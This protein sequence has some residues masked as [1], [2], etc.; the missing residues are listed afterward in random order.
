VSEGSQRQLVLPATASA[1]ETAAIVAALARY[2]SDVEAPE[3]GAA[4]RESEW[5]R[6]ARAEAL[7][8]ELPAF[9]GA[10]EA[11]NQNS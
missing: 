2:L 3:S 9:W 7:R 1:E 4:Q 11:L 5:L 6:T 8:G 10:P